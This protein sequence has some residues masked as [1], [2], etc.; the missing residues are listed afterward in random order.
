MA[1]ISQHLE[2]L[3]AIRKQADDKRTALIDAAEAR[4]Q[5]DLTP[6]E[7]T[8]FR[9]RTAHIKEL[10]ELIVEQREELKRS[11]RLDPD[12]QRVLQASGGGGG[13][14]LAGQQILTREQRISDWCRDNG[15]DD[16]QGQPPLSF[17]K[18][19]RGIAV[20]DWTGAREE[21]VLSEGT[22]TAGGHLVPLPLASNVL[23][24]ARNASRVVQA[25]AVTV[26]MTSQTLKIAR[27]TGEPAPAWRAEN[28]PVTAGDLTFDAV[29]F[30][31]RSLDRMVI[32]SRELLEDSDP[33]A[34]DV[35]A[36]SFAEQLGLEVDRV[37]LRGSGTAPEPRGVLNTSGITTTTHGAN[38]AAL[39]NYDFFLDAAGAVAGANYEANAHIVAPRTMTS[40][41]KLK[42][43]TTNAYLQ[44]PSDLLPMLPTKQIPINLTVGTSTDCTEVFTGQWNAL[45]IGI[46]TGF[47]L[48]MLTERYADNQQVA[49]L[50]HLRADVQ[51][52][53]PTAFVVD[54][55]VRA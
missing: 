53:Q 8:E 38:G 32:L 30:T 4:G 7:T 16:R 26:P 2:R 22:L 23:D 44:P 40:L 42:E 51:V 29:T 10:D 37:A 54:T 43:A 5:T 47:Q 11:G 14:Q 19:V 18:F 31:A 46:R 36:H 52:L 17:D 21:R 50:A 15:H 49:F 33:S 13:Q 41:S 9:Q 6:E 3:L 25:G 12:A 55:G 39:A 35:I 1:G 48:T 27:L 45:A 20:G 34:S 28:A 24:L